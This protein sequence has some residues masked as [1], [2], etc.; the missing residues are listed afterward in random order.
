MT[1]ATERLI[2]LSAIVI[3]LVIFVHMFYHPQSRKSKIQATA[4][5]QWSVGLDT[6]FKGIENNLEWL[7]KRISDPNDIIVPE[8]DPNEPKKEGEN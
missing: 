5:Q 6:R 3:G 1:R 4:I 7:R 8:S 2:W